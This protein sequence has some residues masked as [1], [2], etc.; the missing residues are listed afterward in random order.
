M[1]EIK[2]EVWYLQL[3]KV[4]NIEYILKI[5]GKSEKFSKKYLTM[6]KMWYNHYTVVK[7]NLKLLNGCSKA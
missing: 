2:T 3:Y 7:I 4:K 5:R 1:V 6:S